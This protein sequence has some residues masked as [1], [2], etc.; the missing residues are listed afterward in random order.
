M[1]YGLD[2]F[3]RFAVNVWEVDTDG[4]S[5]E[6]I[7]EEGLSRTEG[8]FVRIRRICQQFLQKN[9]WQILY[10]MVTLADC[11]KLKKFWILRQF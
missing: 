6:Q 7:A 11:R 1:P 8:R 2:K 3:R 9:C 10:L 4:K 5:D